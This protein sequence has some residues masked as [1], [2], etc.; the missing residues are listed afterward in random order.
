[1]KFGATA[2]FP[3]TIGFNMN[4][5]TKTPAD[6][7]EKPVEGYILYKGK[8][9]PEGDIQEHWW[10]N[11]CGNWGSTIEKIAAEC[12]KRKNCTG[13]TLKDG[14]PW[15]LKKGEIK[16]FMNTENDA[17][18]D[19]YVKENNMTQKRKSS[20]RKKKNIRYKSY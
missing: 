11:D 5:K 3:K 10:R 13:F 9:R 16:L 2:N 14:K 8:D 15:C 19:L 18:H 4:Q 1:M 6:R 12:D 17:S 20:S 7:T